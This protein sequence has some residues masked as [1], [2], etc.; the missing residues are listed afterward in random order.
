[1]E[2]KITVSDLALIREF[3]RLLKKNKIKISFLAE[4]AGFSRSL[5]YRILNAERPINVTH[6]EA[7]HSFFLEM[8]IDDTKLLYLYFEAVNMRI[9]C[10][11]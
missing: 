2:V 5:V 10:L 1:M 4:R 9:K 7:L 6:I 3:R 11:N 8:G